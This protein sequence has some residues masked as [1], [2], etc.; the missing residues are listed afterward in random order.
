MQWGV[1]PLSDNTPEDGYHYQMTVHTGMRKN[2]GTES[3][4]FFM[5]GGEQGD[6]EV[7]KLEDTLKRVRI[8]ISLNVPVVIENIRLTFLKSEIYV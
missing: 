5:L 3:T 6:T 2:A 7:R 4:V 8:V 1:V